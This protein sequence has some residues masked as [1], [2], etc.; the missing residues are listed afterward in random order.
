MSSTTVNNGIAHVADVLRSPVYASKEVLIIIP[1]IRLANDK[2]TN[3][4]IEYFGAISTF[5]A[6]NE[7]GTQK[8]CA[9]RPRSKEDGNQIWV[10]EHF[11]SELALS[12]HRESS[13]VHSML[14]WLLNDEPNGL[15]SLPMPVPLQV[16]EGSFVQKTVADVQ[17]PF[18]V[19]T[20]IG[21]EPETS[22]DVKEI[23][24]NFGA[25][26]RNQAELLM[27]LPGRTG[28]K[29]WAIAAY[30]SEQSYEDNGL[31]QTRF[32]E[33]TKEQSLLGWKDIFLEIKAGYLQRP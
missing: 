24:G 2:A 3:K 9:F 13:Q 4:Y 11:D 16:M 25:A 28:N 31:V 8:F 19:L 26:A 30:R 5:S 10:L 32:K 33:A 27:F 23:I 20:Q 1:N 18:V 14:S 15:H 7:S 22:T 17:D 29:I 6:A 21:F 12:K